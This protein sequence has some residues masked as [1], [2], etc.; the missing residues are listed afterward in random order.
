MLVTDV[1]I[2]KMP[3]GKAWGHFFKRGK[4]KGELQEISCAG[5]YQWEYVKTKESITHD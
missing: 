3:Y 4:E 1:K 5:C 2:R